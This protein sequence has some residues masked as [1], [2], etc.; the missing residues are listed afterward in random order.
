MKIAQVIPQGDSI[1]VVTV[2]GA[3][4]LGWWHHRGEQESVWKW[5]KLPA[6]PETDNPPPKDRSD[7]Q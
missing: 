7:L 6:L 4:Y 1:I 5:E 2:E 3:I